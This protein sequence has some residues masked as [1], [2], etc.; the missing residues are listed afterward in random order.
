MR[1]SVIRLIR[2]SVCCRLSREHA[3]LFHWTVRFTQVNTKPYRRSR[4]IHNTHPGP[5]RRTI[6]V[7]LGE[8][9]ALANRAV[10]PHVASCGRSL[11]NRALVC[12]GERSYLDGRSE[13]PRPGDVCGNLADAGRR[14]Q[15]DLGYRCNL[16]LE[17]LHDRCPLRVR[18]SQDLG[19]DHPDHRDPRDLRLGLPVPRRHV[20]PHRRDRGRLVSRRSMRCS[21][22]PRTRSGR[23]RSS[24]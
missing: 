12:A 6:H 14:A 11:C 4:D 5:A 1:T 9:G 19:V 3:P 2:R 7:H 8:S 10:S 21:R 15:C 22:S 24:L 18:Q 23:S 13:R 17:V 20:R 16:E